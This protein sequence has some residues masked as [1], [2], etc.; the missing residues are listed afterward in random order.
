MTNDFFAGVTQYFTQHIVCIN[1]FIIFINNKNA[2]MRIFYD[3][4]I[5]FFAFFKLL[6]HLLSFCYISGNS[7]KND[8]VV[9]FICR[10]RKFN[11]KF[12]SILFQTFYFYYSL[13]LSRFFQKCFKPFFMFF[14][15]FFRH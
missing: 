5:F 4:T 3:G 12:F 8:G 9:S 6:F 1:K 2:S 13:Q 15:I 11:R 14:F 10:K 7:N